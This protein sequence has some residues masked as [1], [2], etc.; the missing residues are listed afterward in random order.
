MTR[1][2]AQSPY[3]TAHPPALALYITLHYIQLA[4]HR[5]HPS[6][7][8]R[9]APKDPQNSK[10]RLKRA[11]ETFDNDARNDWLEHLQ[12]KIRK[13]LN[14]PDDPGPSRSPSPFEVADGVT[15][16]QGADLENLHPHAQQDHDDELDEVITNEDGE[17]E[18]DDEYEDENQPILRDSNLETGISGPSVG[19]IAMDSSPQLPSLVAPLSFA[20]QEEALPVQVS[21]LNH[22]Y[23]RRASADIVV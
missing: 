3:H 9:A 21:L 12:Q 7:M 5:P 1:R 23:S 11:Y 8:S 15:T 13:G 4:Q 22:T 6:Q 17:M 16:S 18:Y 19:V 14:P 10:I 20:L 2:S